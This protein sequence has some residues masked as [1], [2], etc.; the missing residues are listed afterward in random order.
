MPLKDI[1]TFY[2]KSQA[3]WRAWLEENHI[4]EYSVWVIYYKKYLGKPTIS[5]SEAVD[6]ALCFGWIDS[7]KKK[8]D[9]ERSIQFFSKRKPKSTWSKINKEKVKVLSKN[10][11][12]VKAGHKCI[13]MAKENG[14]W[15]ILDTVEA[16]IIPDDLEIAFAS[17][18]NAKEYFLGLSKSLQKQILTWIVLAR[19]EDTRQNR[20]TEIA[21]MA[22][23]QKMPKHL[24]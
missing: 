23:L 4:T 7:L 5:W 21:K 16:L 19:R 3:E 15:N 9:E 20:I 24:G 1:K 8:I 17:H 11:Q 22:A 12:M 13:E 2:P 10:G 18:L 6:E 14:Y